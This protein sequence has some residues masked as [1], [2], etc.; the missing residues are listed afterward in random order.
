MDWLGCIQSGAI[1]VQP[2]SSVLLERTPIRSMSGCSIFFFLFSSGADAIDL[3]P[4]LR[5]AHS[6]LPILHG[7]RHAIPPKGSRCL[8]CSA[9]SFLDGGVSGLHFLFSSLIFSV[10]YR[11]HVNYEQDQKDAAAAGRKVAARAVNTGIVC[12]Y[13]AS[14]TFATEEEKVAHFRETHQTR[15]C[16]VA[17]AVS[18][19][20]AGRCGAVS[21]H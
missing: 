13:C 8:T 2:G 9:A 4:V 3:V 14:M 12:V 20:Y 21:Y 18:C 10:F 15:Y 16:W 7:Y 11:Q 6:G 19:S 17:A 1:A 5:R